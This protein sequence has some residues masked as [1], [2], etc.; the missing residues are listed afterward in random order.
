M[1]TGN[2]LMADGELRA[3]GWVRSNGQRKTGHGVSSGNLRGREPLWVTQ[4]RRDAAQLTCCS[5]QVANGLM[6]SSSSTLED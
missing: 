1:Q 4:T 6:A 5:I 2:G 3:P